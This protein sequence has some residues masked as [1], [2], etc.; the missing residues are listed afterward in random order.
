M[1]HLD[2]CCKAHIHPRQPLPER[3]SA[4][5]AS[6]ANRTQNPL[7]K[8][9]LFALESPC[10]ETAVA[11]PLTL[12]AHAPISYEARRGLVSWP[13]QEGIACLLA[14]G[15]HD[16]LQIGVTDRPP[17]PADIAAWRMCRL[18]GACWIR[19]HGDIAPTVVTSLCVRGLTCLIQNPSASTSVHESATC[20]H[21]R[22]KFGSGISISPSP[23]FFLWA[24][25]R[26]RFRARAGSHG[27]CSRLVCAPT[28]S[29]TPFDH[30]PH[31]SSR[32]PS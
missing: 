22:G 20:I 23:L 32:R 11:E 1:G 21:T 16:L 27:C 26:A 17:E 6:F 19:S 31:L 29:A 7:I 28:T 10:R 30:G 14:D 13:G 18:S 15:C 12:H 2:F 5:R 25:D 4:R 3:G 9:A 8:A 24:Q